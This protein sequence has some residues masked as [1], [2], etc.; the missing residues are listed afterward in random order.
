M[1]RERALERSFM[2]RPIDEVNQETLS[3]KVRTRVIKRQAEKEREEEENKRLEERKK[4]STLRQSLFPNM[5]IY[6]NF[7][8]ANSLPGIVGRNLSGGLKNM[9]WHVWAPRGKNATPDKSQDESWTIQSK[10]YFLDSSYKLP[11]MPPPQIVL[12][13]LALGSRG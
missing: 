5:P 7:V 11:L 10:N 4:A 12:S 3:D 1:E 6:I 2:S 8:T 9:G 13:T